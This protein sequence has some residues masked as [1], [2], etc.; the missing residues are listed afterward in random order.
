MK[1]IHFKTLPVLVGMISSFVVSDS[2]AA[3]IHSL[4]DLPRIWSG[5]AGDLFV[6]GNARMSLGQAAEISRKTS[7]G[8]TVV[9]YN[10]RGELEL[11][12]RRFA[13]QSA[14]MMLNAGYENRAE[15][16]LKLADPLIPS[17][18]VVARYNEQEKVFEL[19]E[20]LDVR[21]RESRFALRALAQ[22]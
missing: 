7:G 21:R 11:S 10:V 8:F 9:D 4:N 13:I 3:V 12:G 22:N 20:S 15:I 19:F 16:I 14:Q 2:S 6:R 5:V 17:L 1:A 18:F